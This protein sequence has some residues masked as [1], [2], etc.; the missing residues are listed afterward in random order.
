VLLEMIFDSTQ[1]SVPKTGSSADA[2]LVF[3]IPSVV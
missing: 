2:M 1:F 3:V